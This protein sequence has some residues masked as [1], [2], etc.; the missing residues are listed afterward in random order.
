MGIAL[1]ES[2]VTASVWGLA[3]AYWISLIIV[4]VT[5]MVAVPR[6]VVPLGLILWP[7]ILVMT[8]AGVYDGVWTRWWFWV[9]TAVSEIAGGLAVFRVDS[10][11]K[12][13]KDKESPD[14][15]YIGRPPGNWRSRS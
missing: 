2:L 6:I 4:P 12:G 9:L 14:R 8:Q 13:L 1:I 11:S 10:K 3:V 15:A 5:Y 7:F